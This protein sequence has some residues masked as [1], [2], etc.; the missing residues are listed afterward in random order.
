MTIFINITWEKLNKIDSTEEV[1]LRNLDRESCGKTTSLLWSLLSR[2]QY[3]VHFHYLLFYWWRLKNDSN[4]QTFVKFWKKLLNLSFLISLGIFKFIFFH[5]Q[6]QK[7]IKYSLIIFPIISSNANNSRILIISFPKPAIII[8][9]HKSSS[10][11]IN[12]VDI[13]DCCRWLIMLMMVMFSLYYWLEMMVNDDW[14]WWLVIDIWWLLM[15]ADVY[16]WIL[17]I[18]G[19]IFLFVPVGL[20]FF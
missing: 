13:G 11:I 1:L 3:L 8:N 2:W 7:I 9:H 17:M 4:H 20:L 15:I 10:L 19:E 14:Y 16:S 6:K 5:F 12:N 18:V